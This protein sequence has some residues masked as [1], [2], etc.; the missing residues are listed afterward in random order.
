MKPEHA[1]EQEHE[2]RDMVDRLEQEITESWDM[3]HSLHA[4]GG[5]SGCCPVCQDEIRF[6]QAITKERHYA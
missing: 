4:C 6:E 3:A 1:I 5:A 2:F